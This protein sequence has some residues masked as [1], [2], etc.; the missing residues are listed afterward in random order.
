[1]RIR[2]AASV[3][4]SRSCAAR[5]AELAAEVA[6]QELGERDELAQRLLEVVRRH[7]RELLELGVRAR[8]VLV[9]DL[10]RVALARELALRVA[11][12]GDVADRR[13]HYRALSRSRA[14]TG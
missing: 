4:N 8:E 10:E 2:R 12:L 11:H 1:V 3:M 13:R 6:A 5:L 14:G 7:R 9:G